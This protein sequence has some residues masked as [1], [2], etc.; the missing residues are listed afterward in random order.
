MDE[1]DRIAREKHQILI[2]CLN[3]KVVDDHR[4]QECKVS[5][6]KMN[7]AFK[8]LRSR[9]NEKLKNGKVSQVLTGQLTRHCAQIGEKYRLKI[10]NETKTV[11]EF[12]DSREIINLI[13]LLENNDERIQ[14]KTFTGDCLKGLLHIHHNPF[15]TLGASLYINTINYWYLNAKLRK[16]RRKE[17]K[18]LLEKNDKL[19]L[20]QRM[21]DKATLPRKGEQRR[22]TAEWLI[23]KKYNGVNYY[24]CLAKHEEGDQEI[25]DNKI[26]PCLEEFGELAES[27]I[28]PNT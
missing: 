6:D 15:A 10:G 13:E 24:L 3:S 14:P 12:F 9:L 11:C 22:L 25:Y 20:G 21:I 18:E 17:F 28:Y 1:L 26:K 16:K 27:Y 2:Q 7:S 23:F 8:E 19:T 4:V 5:A